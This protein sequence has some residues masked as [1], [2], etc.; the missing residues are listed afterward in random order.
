MQ[1]QQQLSSDFGNCAT[2]LVPNVMLS[3]QLHLQLSRRQEQLHQRQLQSQLQLQQA[4]LQEQQQIISGSDHC[5]DSAAVSSVIPASTLH[6]TTSCITPIPQ[7]TSQNIA[8]YRLSEEEGAQLAEIEEN[9]KRS[10]EYKLVIFYFYIFYFL[11]YTSEN[12]LMR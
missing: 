5:R 11:L 7:P 4:Q 2:H 8:E 6:Y 3:Q 10:A 9:L 12:C 1:Q